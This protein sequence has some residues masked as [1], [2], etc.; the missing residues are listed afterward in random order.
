MSEIPDAFQTLLAAMLV[1]A[2]MIAAAPQLF[3]DW[4]RRVA[5]RQRAAVLRQQ[6]IQE[7]LLRKL[8]LRDQVRSDI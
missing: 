7:D 4:L 2:A 6:A 1:A 3:V 8:E 5:E